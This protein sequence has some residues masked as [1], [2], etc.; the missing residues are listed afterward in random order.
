MHFSDKNILTRSSALP[1]HTLPYLD[2]LN[3][4][5]VRKIPPRVL[6]WRHCGAQEMTPFIFCWST[7]V[8]RYALKCK[9]GKATAPTLCTTT[10]KWR[11]RQQASK[12]VVSETT[13]AQQ[14]RTYHTKTYA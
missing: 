14:V 12:Y 5:Q 7:N 11:Q 6:L 2:Y 8:R 3:N 13:A 9:I 10:F 4:L 1:Y